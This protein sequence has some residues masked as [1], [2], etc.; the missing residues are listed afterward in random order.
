MRT[1]WASH[2]LLA[3]PSLVIIIV[4]FTVIQMISPTIFL[5][6][7]VLMVSPI[8]IFNLLYLC[9]VLLNYFD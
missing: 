3:F 4:M 9:Y 1:V 8:L 7:L 2:H 6:G 5:Y